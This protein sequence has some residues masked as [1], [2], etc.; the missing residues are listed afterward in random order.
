MYYRQSNKTKSTRIFRRKT[1]HQ[2]LND[3]PQFTSL[4]PITTCCIQTTRKENMFH[5]LTQQAKETT[6]FA[7]SIPKESSDLNILSL[8]FAFIHESRIITFTI[9]YSPERDHNKPFFWTLEYF[10]IILFQSSKAIYTWGNILP[11]LKSIK[12]YDLFTNDALRQA[13]FIDIQQKFTPWYNNLFGHELTCQQY[14]KYDEID[15]HLCSCTHRPYKSSAC[16]WSLSKAIM[17]TFN[18]RFSDCPHGIAQ[19][20]AIAKLAHAIDKIET[21][22]ELTKLK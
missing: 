19:C 15:G 18:E 3:L 10:F 22:E 2:K 5:V 20:L 6:L 13:N 21:I 8:N 17:Y 1:L 16:Q 4:L 14:L 12:K 11:H 9:D 7:M